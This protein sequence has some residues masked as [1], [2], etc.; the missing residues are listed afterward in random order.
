M[1]LLPLGLSLMGPA[2]A[3]DDPMAVETP[4]AGGHPL[5]QHRASLMRAHRTLQYT[6]AAALTLTAAG[7][8]IAAMNKPTLFG[9][10]R[11]VSGDPNPRRLRLQRIQ[12]HPRHGRR[13]HDRLVR[14]DDDRRVVGAEAPRR[15]RGRTRPVRPRRLPSRRDLGRTSSASRRCRSSDSPARTPRCSASPARTPGASARRCARC[16][17][18]SACSLRARSSR[19]W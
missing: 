13:P 15:P 10:G 7:G 18:A 16:M 1:L 12:P 4:R 3:A 14:G 8:V 2:R 17:Q 19:R 11:C 5:A 6:T 9:D